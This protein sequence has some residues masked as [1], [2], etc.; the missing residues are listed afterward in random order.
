MKKMAALLTGVLLAAAI[1][2]PAMAE[3]DYTIAVNL[4][5]LSS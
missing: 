2:V 1:S 5:T 4:K 3:E